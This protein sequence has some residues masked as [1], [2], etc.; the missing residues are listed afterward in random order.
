MTTASVRARFHPDGIYLNTPTYGLP[1]NETIDALEE[2]LERWTKGVATMAEYDDAV[3]RSREVFAQIVNVDPSTV[4]VANQVSVLAG[5]VAASLPPGTRVLVADG[6]FTSILFPLLVNEERGIEVRS[7]PLTQLAEAVDANTDLV[8]FS[9]V[10]SSDGRIADID[11]I[12]AAARAKGA[13]LLVDTTQA[14]GWLPVEAARFDYT[15][16]AAYKWLL[17]PRGTAFLTLGQNYDASMLPLYAGWYA[18]D[19]VWQSIYGLPLRLAEDA[20]RYDLS[21]AWFSWMGSV[22]SLELIAGLGVDHIHRHNLAL[23]RQTRE[24]L[25]L[26]ASESAVVT[27]PLGDTSALGERGIGASVR[28]NAVRVGFHLY[29]DATDVAALVKAIRGAPR[30]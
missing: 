24:E 25:S 30:G 9:L 13:R 7:A 8:A 12:E 1:P 20:R 18:G 26:P 19:D 17:C 3:A 15:V 23:A 29:N 4:A 27:V 16:T 21:P 10:Q 6:D 5:L 22:P 2:A 11:A 14:V 28:S